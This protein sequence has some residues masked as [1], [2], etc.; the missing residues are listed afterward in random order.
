VDVI[1]A[2]IIAGI[3]AMLVSA[4]SATAAFVVTSASIRNGTIQTVDISA[5]ARRALKG[6]RGPAGGRGPRGPAGP[7]GIQRLRPVTSAVV[8]IAPGVSAS[9]IAECNAGEVAVSGGFAFGGTVMFSGPSP[10]RRGWLVVAYNNLSDVPI[11]LEASA[12][13]AS[14]IRVE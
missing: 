1:K 6:N 10:S 13:C 5:K 14:G 8:P 4:A 7:A 11:R 2:A 9:A 12:Y 3:V